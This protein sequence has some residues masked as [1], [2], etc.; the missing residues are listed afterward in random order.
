MPYH[1]RL[2]DGGE[3]LRDAAHR[4]PG[5]EDL[6]KLVL[7]VHAVLDREHARVR[8]DDRLDDL[9]PVLR[10]ERLDAEQDQ[11]GRREAIQTLD[12]GSANR[13]L[14]LDRGLDP[15]SALANGSEMLAARDERH[16]L[17][18]PRE[19]RAEVSARSAA[20][21]HDDAH[22]IPSVGSTRWTRLG[23]LRTEAWH[24]IASSAEN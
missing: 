2:R 14:A 7:V 5:P 21:H 8:P 11:I 22:L 13:P 9:G 4:V 23:L 3:D 20:P 1:A 10:V 19:L 17:P 16:V 15:Q 18:R 24:G 12:G 6:R